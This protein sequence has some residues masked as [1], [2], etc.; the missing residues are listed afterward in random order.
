MLL[1][2]APNHGTYWRHH[3]NRD[4]SMSEVL[5]G[6]SRSTVCVTP[7]TTGMSCRDRNTLEM[8]MVLSEP[9]ND[10][11]TCVAMLM[12][13]TMRVIVMT[14]PVAMFSG[15]SV[16]KRLVLEP[17]MIAEGNVAEMRSGVP[18]PEREIHS[19][20][21]PP[22]VAPCANIEGLLPRLRERPRTL[23]LRL[24]AMGTIRL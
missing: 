9:P 20:C 4:D 13:P 15:R 21:L 3:M 5:E 24:N 19:S 23:R 1:L 11:M 18:C 12:C 22:G 8:A 10:V 2:P 16:T 14:E 17:T 6:D 7:E